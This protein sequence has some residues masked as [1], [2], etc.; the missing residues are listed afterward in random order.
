MVRTKPLRGSRCAS[1]K[2]QGR[3]PL[4]P[5]AFRTFFALSSGRPRWGDAW[6][7]R[8]D[9]PAGNE[10]GR[11][12]DTPAAEDG[13]RHEDPAVRGRHSIQLHLLR[14][15]VHA[16]IWTFAGT[17][18]RPTCAA[19]SRIRRPRARSATAVST[20][21]PPDPSSD[22]NPAPLPLHYPNRASTV[23][24]QLLPTLG[25]KNHLPGGR[26]HPPAIALTTISVIRGPAP[27]K[28]E[29]CPTCLQ[30]AYSRTIRF[31]C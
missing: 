25:I 4:E 3:Q 16:A 17:T 8:P 27:L 5:I 6:P 23:G 26:V 11:I 1:L 19:V 28:T 21:P 2:P 20:A 14:G 7:S 15:A 29:S 13:R 30:V 22:P 24:G 9:F 10:G 12:D 18:S 31:D